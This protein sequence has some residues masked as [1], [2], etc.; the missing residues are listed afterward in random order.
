MSD[1]TRDR[2]AD[3][4]QTAGFVD[5]VLSAREAAAALNINERTVRRAIAGGELPAVKRAGVYRITQGDLARYRVRRDGRVRTASRTHREAPRLIPFPT[6]DNERAPDLPRPLTPLV[7]REAEQLAIRALLLRPDVPLVTLTGPGGV[8]K[9]R[10]ALAV[11]ADLREAFSGAVWFVDLAPLA[12][13][14]LVP[15]TIAGALGVRQIGEESLT[16]RVSAFLQKQQVLLLLDNFERIT[17]AAPVV[18]QLLAACPRLT[19]LVTSRVTLR[20]SGEHRFPVAPLTLPDSSHAGSATEVEEEAAVQLFYLRAR[21]ATPDFALTDANASA[22]A[23]VCARLDGLPLAIE[24]AAARSAVLAPSALLARLEHRLPLLTGGPRDLPDRLRTM[25]EAIAWSYEIL[26]P[27]EQS[28]FRRL[29]VFAGGFTLDAAAAVVGTPASPA[30][31][32]V[33]E[34]LSA[35]VDNSLVRQTRQADGEPRFAM[36]ET[37]RE[38]GIEQLIASDEESATRHRHAAWNLTF[39]ER[40]NALIDGRDDR[41]WLDRLEDERDNLRGALDWWLQA[42]DIEAALRLGA[43]LIELWFHRGPVT[44]G[45]TWLQRG[46]EAPANQAVSPAVRVATLQAASLLAWMQRDAGEAAALADESL[47]LA[48]AT[49]DDAH[50]AWALNLLGLAAVAEGHDTEAAAHFDAAL[51]LYRTLG[52]HSPLAVALMNRAT[53]AGPHRARAYLEEAMTICRATGDRGGSLVLILNQLARVARQE[54]DDA[55]A[56]RLFAESLRL[57]W[58]AGNLWSLPQALEGL[59]GLAETMGQQ[60]RAAR[61]FGAADTVREEINV[62]RK[63]VEPPTSAHN[64][65]QAYVRPSGPLS[66]PWMWDRSLQVAD[67]VADAIAFASGVVEVA[68]SGDRSVSAPYG[69]TRREIDVL[70]QLV[71]GRSDSQI[72][73]ALFISPHTVRTHV[74]RVLAKLGVGSRTAAVATAFRDGFL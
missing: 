49:G 61:L 38:Y 6:L 48:R 40:I 33:L 22:V 11:A 8:G 56:R 7:G 64:L 41:R 5:A 66:A 12:D 19:V 45:R 21:A 55:E 23:A 52:D 50:Q 3:S 70:Q 16:S 69:L 30:P 47:A 1:R 32:A 24:L 46:L 54:G 35:L 4:G 63:T 18:A 2:T 25:R 37:V 53:V 13:P 31:T 59:A 28:L 74:K 17:A 71:Q 67:A 60:E 42:G 36:L 44:E 58:E 29:A 34:G 14:A 57:C 15:V 43:A 27:T 10:L 9:T 51:A 20:L 39:A 26:N 68:A 62:P 65:S 72:A 73:V